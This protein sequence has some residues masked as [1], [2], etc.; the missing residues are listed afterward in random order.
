MRAFTVRRAVAVWMRC[1]TLVEAVGE[2][3]DIERA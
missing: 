2:K 3:T 1:S